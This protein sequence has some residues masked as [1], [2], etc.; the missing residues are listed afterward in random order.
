MSNA[1]AAVK[2]GVVRK[3]DEFGKESSATLAAATRFYQNAMLGRTTAGYLAKFDDSQSMIFVGIVRGDNGNPLLPAGTAGDGTI[4]LEYQQPQRIE[5]A[6][7]SVTVADIGKP[8]YAS[9]DQ[10]GV[11][12]PNALTY[13]NLIGQI[14][15]VVGTNIALVEP[16]YDGVAGNKRLGAVKV[17]AAT[18]TQTLSKWDI[19]KTIKITNT[20]AHSVNLP[21]VAD[22]A[23]G[24][25]LEF[26]KT[27]AAA[28]AA[29]LDA[30]GTENIDGSTTLATLDAQYDCASLWNSG[31]EWVV[32]NRDIA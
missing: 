23:L 11:I 7:A 17:L 14:V 29:T 2:K 1:T 25:E 24:G 26:V 9:D 13:A 30:D 12:S 21:P 10:T 31:S 3:T 28:F 8:V 18:G 19:G 16:A 27:T 32:K 20:A 22:A 5:L 6:V 15:G 4:D